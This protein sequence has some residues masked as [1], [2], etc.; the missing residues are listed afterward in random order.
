M[1]T[2]Y[3]P[4]P[5]FERYRIHRE[6]KEVQSNALGGRWKPIKVHRN[7]LIRIISNDRTQE[8]AG[9]PIRILY[10]AMR[11]INP[12]KISRDLAVI[13]HNG[14]L[15]LLD[16]RALAERV[17]A[18]K[19]AGRNRAVAAAEYK[20]AIEFCGCVLR[21][22]QTDD[23]TEVVTRI[24]QEK[25]QIEKF[26]RT[27]NISHTEQRVNEIWMEAFDITLSHIRA[28][29]SFIANLP[30]YLRR[31]VAAIHARQVK[32]NK[33]LRSYDNPETKLARII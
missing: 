3:L 20:A 24:W 4:I 11:G 13:E 27:R 16:R 9:R 15:Q 7:G 30:A 22:Y 2:N 21:A 29:G 5:G 31:T 12:A 6:T 32:V 23:Y 19:K 1:E 8:Y 25:P 28:N 10:A 33:I 14:E 17:Q 18:T 26:M